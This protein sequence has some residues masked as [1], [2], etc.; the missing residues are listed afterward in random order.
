[1]P[2]ALA[3]IEQKHRRVRCAETKNNPAHDES[4]DDT[5]RI[6]KAD[7]LTGQFDW[8]RSSRLTAAPDGS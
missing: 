8:R 6:L 3:A 7:T 1:M 4:P 2:W 5:Q